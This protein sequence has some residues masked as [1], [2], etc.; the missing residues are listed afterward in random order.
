MDVDTGEAIDGAT[1]GADAFTGDAADDIAPSD[2]QVEIGFVARLVEELT[3]SKEIASTKWFEAQD[4]LAE[5]QEL[6]NAI[7]E[8]A[9]EVQQMLI[10]IRNTL[11]YTLGSSHRDYQK[12]RVTKSRHDADESVDELEIDEPI[13]ES[14]SVEP[15]NNRPVATS[16][17]WGSIWALLK[18]KTVGA[19]SS[20]L[21]MACPISESNL[22]LQTFGILYF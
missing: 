12:L 13:Q 15:E 2:N 9:I 7:R 6:R 10:L 8:S 16:P 18:H 14:D 4:Y 3:A 22:P 1:A 21:S 19:S 11:R 5:E 20:H 17:A